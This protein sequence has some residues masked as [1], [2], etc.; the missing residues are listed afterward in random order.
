[1]D[2]RSRSTPVGVPL[3]RENLTFDTLQEILR[4]W[5][6]ENG[7]V[8]S[9]ENVLRDIQEALNRGHRATDPDRARELLGLAVIYLTRYLSIKGWLAS[10]VAERAWEDLTDWSWQQFREQ[11]TQEMTG[12][13]VTIPLP[14]PRSEHTEVNDPRGTVLPFT[15]EWKG[16][17]PRPPQLSQEEIDRINEGTRRKSVG[18]PLRTVLGMLGM[19]L[20]GDGFTKLDDKEDA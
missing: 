5:D 9:S 19:V 10:E 8:D 11:M 4:E 14:K 6:F 16:E 18:D 3:D 1:M 12:T 7:D 20:K 15:G 13:E 17:G 2:R